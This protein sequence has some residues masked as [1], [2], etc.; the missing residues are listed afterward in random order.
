MISRSILAA[1]VAAGTAGSALADVR[2]KTPGMDLKAPSGG[3]DL[4]LDIDR[5]LEP[6][7]AWVGRAV[8]S[9]DG[10]RL[11]EVAAVVEDSMYV[12]M[13]GFLGIGESRVLLHQSQIGSATEERIVVKMTEVDAKTLP[14]TDSR[15]NPPKQQ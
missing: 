11:G 14:S 5:R 4:N 12:D 8:Y 9:I 7:Q 13:G 1:V 15:A 3:V 10:K 2:V 6:K